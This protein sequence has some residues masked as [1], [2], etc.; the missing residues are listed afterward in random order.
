MAP[1]S[2]IIGFAFDL[3]QD[4]TVAGYTSRVFYTMS[5]I[6]LLFVSLQYLRLTDTFSFMVISI[7][8]CVYKILDFVWFFVLLMFFF[9]VAFS[10]IGYKPDQTDKMNIYVAN[11]FRVFNGAMGDFDTS[12]IDTLEKGPYGTG[13]L[14]FLLLAFF[15]T[16]VYMN[17]LIAVVSDEFEKVYE[18]KDELLLRK[19]LP[20][21]IKNWKSATYSMCLGSLFSSSSTD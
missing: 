5:T 11:F 21:I 19:R 12:D 20:Y 16:I 10:I 17:I 6:A 8:A 4:K 14:L 13:Y 7:I 1:L 18:T 2:Y 3:Y 9:T 15:T